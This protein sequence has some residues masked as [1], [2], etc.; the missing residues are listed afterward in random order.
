MKIHVLN[1]GIEKWAR[2]SSAKQPAK[3]CAKKTYLAELDLSQRWDK[4]LV[5]A[6]SLYLQVTELW[7]VQAEE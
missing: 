1:I 6:G 3:R 2:S 5:L 4:T 7:A